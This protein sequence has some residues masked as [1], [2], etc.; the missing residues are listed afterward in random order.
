MRTVPRRAERMRPNALV[1]LWT[2]TAIPS[3]AAAFASAGFLLAMVYPLG[4]DRVTFG[5]FKDAV[6]GGV[7]G[8]VW[9]CTLALP[10]AALLR[11][12]VSL[13]QRFGSWSANP[14]STLIAVACCAVPQAAVLGAVIAPP[15]GL[16]A[17][18]G[19]T[20]GLL[21]PPLVVKRLGF[22]S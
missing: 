17:W 1:L 21:L 14:A 6:L 10:H 15:I 5:P 18:T 16:V 19:V 7:S 4:F 12:Y 3:T 2:L 9:A 20:L 11:V 8:G 22:V 13:E